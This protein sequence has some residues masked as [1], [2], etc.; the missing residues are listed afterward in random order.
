MGS[1]LLKSDAKVDIPGI[2]SAACDAD[3]RLFD[4]ASLYGHT[5]TIFAEEIIACATKKYP[6]EIFVIAKGDLEGRPPIPEYLRILHDSKAQ[7]LR[8]VV[9]NHHTGLQ[10]D[11]T[12]AATQLKDDWGFGEDERLFG[13]GVSNCYQRCLENILTQCNEK[14]YDL[15]M[16]NEIEIGPMSMQGSFVDDMKA[17]GILPI[18]YSATRVFEKNSLGDENPY[19]VAT[20]NINNEREKKEAGAEEGSTRKFD[21]RS[22][23]QAYLVFR[24]VAVIPWSTNVERVKHQNSADV[25]DILEHFRDE[26]QSIDDTIKNP[27]NAE[28]NW[29]I[30]NAMPIIET[31]ANAYY[32]PTF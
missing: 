32:S 5:Q 14:G 21:I 18:A 22:V 30:D 2:V 31:A 3:I 26:L 4:M 13:Y 15:P 17:K 10:W 6:Q 11:P 16:V 1:F 8:F 29:H 19:A 24:D 28:E 12:F 25:R 9:V 23:V 20:A 27:V 7:N